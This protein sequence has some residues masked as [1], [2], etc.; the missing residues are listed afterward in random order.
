[1]EDHFRVFFFVILSSETV[2]CKNIVINNNNNDNNN[3]AN[4]NLK[5]KQ[6]WG[7]QDLRRRLKKAFDQRDM[8]KRKIEVRD[9]YK[10]GVDEIYNWWLENA[11]SPGKLSAYIQTFGCRSVQKLLDYARRYLKEWDFSDFTFHRERDRMERQINEDLRRGYSSEE[12]WDLFDVRWHHFEKAIE[13]GASYN[14]EDS[15]KLFKQ[16]LILNNI[17]HN[18]PLDL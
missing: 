18:E 11:K 5:I 12:W 8:M 1:M 6:V 2:P 3:N 9:S 13:R 17:N 15:L 16:I 7:A 10:R 14:L 4:R